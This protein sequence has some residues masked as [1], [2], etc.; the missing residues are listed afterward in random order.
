MVTEIISGMPVYLQLEATLRERIGSGELEVGSRLPSESQLASQ[1]GVSR[2]TVRKALGR[3]ATDGLITKWP[4]KGSYVSAER[5]KMTPT[6]LSFS[7]QMIAAGHS[8]GTK[9]LL[10]RV[11]LAPE[12]IA[13]SLDLPPNAQII[14]QRTDHPFPSAAVAGWRTGCHSRHFSTPSAVRGDH[15]R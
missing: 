1:F 2:S 14:P 8:V 4:G 15:G 3:L 12:H 9:V 6:S 7:R 10:R 5:L 13:R 11:L